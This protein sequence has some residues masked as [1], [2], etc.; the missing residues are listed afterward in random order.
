MNRRR[1]WWSVSERLF[2]W[3]A[4]RPRVQSAVLVFMT[5]AALLGYFNPSFVRQL[6]G[7]PPSD[8]RSRERPLQRSAARPQR[9]A[10]SP[11]VRPFQVAGGECVVVATSP[12]FF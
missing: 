6:V 5:F 4:D 7:A 10:Q 12:H 2:G 3:W 11:N 9:P 1:D 8:Y